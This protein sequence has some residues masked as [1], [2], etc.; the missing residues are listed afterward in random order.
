MFSERIIAE[1]YN[2]QVLHSQRMNVTPLHPW[3]IA[4]KNGK[5]LAGHCNCMA[6]LGESCTHVAALLFAIEAA[7]RIRETKT[8]TAE[9]AY[10]VLPSSLD[11]VPYSPV[12]DID[13]TSPQ[14]KMKTLD[15]DIDQGAKTQ[16]KRPTKPANRIPHPTEK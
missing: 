10:W 13:F 16:A 3:L 6:G 4:E 12:S 11:K 1:Y 15:N 5:I 7:V 2:F 9:K 8:V 14:T